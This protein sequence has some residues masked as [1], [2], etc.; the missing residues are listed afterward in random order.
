M[1]YPYMT[2]GD[3]TEITH[4]GIQADQSVKVYIET[5]VH[6]GFHH[7]T[8]ILPSYEWIETYGY[9]DEEIK[10]FTDF[11]HHNA[12]LILEFAAEGGF[13]NAAAI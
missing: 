1:L 5:P 9:S 4:S 8:C 10:D 6:G 2:L 7:A 3:N 13:L 11:L 12:H